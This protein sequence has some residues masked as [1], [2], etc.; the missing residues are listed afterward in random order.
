[1]TV[2]ESPTTT[3]DTKPAFER[4]VREILHRR[5]WVGNGDF[6][7]RVGRIVKQAM[8]SLD[9]K[10]A[11][12]GSS[13]MIC[14][15]IESTFDFEIAKDASYGNRVYQIL[16]HR[17]PNSK[18][19]QNPDAVEIPISQEDMEREWWS[20]VTSELEELDIIWDGSTQRDIIEDLEHLFDIRRYVEKR[21]EDCKNAIVG[22]V[23][24]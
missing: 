22:G 4:E 24:K 14:R 20:S 16:G 21:I 15:V 9:L 18:E 8:E 12:H 5:L 11:P 10:R 3:D 23:T 1:M 19:I 13:V 7:I 6:Q 17:N 2:S